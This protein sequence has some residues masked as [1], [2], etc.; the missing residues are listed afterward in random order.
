MV[1][2]E[3]HIKKYCWTLRIFY[4]VNHYHTEEILDELTAVECPSNIL[5]RVRANLLRSDMD[6]GFTYS[7]KH[8]RQTVMVIGIFSSRPQFL[9]S[10]EHELRHLVDD[11]ADVAGLEPAGEDVAYLTGGINELLAADV[12]LFLCDCTHCHGGKEERIY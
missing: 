10:L 1:S 4:A 5:Q 11:I 3:V 7:N 12:Q 2:N 8:R 6:S 9:N